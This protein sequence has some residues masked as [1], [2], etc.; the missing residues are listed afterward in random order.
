MSLGMW[1]E[2]SMRRLPAWSFE[3]FDQMSS[4]TKSETLDSGAW[5][6]QCSAET[7]RPL[8]MGSDK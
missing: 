8:A 7:K 6:G 2:N 5:I 3:Q 1:W 4:A